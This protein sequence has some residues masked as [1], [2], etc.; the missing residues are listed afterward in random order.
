MRSKNDIAIRWLV[1]STV[2]IMATFI[3]SCAANFPYFTYSR[4]V[5][6][7]FENGIVYTDH[8]YYVGGPV[9]KPNAIIALQKE[10]S[11]NAD[12]WKEIDVDRETLASMVDRIGF[13][14]GA[15][16]KSRRIP[17]G[18]RIIAPDGRQIGIWYSVYNYSIVKMVDENT[19]TLSL[20]PSTLPNGI[21]TEG[22]RS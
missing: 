20:P 13:V 10:F 8:R 14:V 16:E 5:T 6:R 18:A 19:V 4:D 12:K 2:M 1:G 7:A 11:L 21:N 15:E 22:L 9:A 17:N 3:I